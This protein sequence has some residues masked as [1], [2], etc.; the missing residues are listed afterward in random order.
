[1]EILL[2]WQKVFLKEKLHVEIYS[3][4][5]K[6]ATELYGYLREDEREKQ[7]AAAVKYLSTDI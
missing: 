4:L 7:R 1:M 5:L 6:V 2:F 3:D